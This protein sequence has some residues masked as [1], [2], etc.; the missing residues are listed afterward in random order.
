M[1]SNETLETIYTRR[2]VRKYKDQEVN[3]E[4]IEQVI[5]A[6]RMAPSAINMQPW[7]FYVLT[8]K[9]KIQ[10]YSKAIKSVAAKQVFKMGFKNLVKT[11]VSAIKMSHGISFHKEKDAVFHGAPVVIF[12][13]GDVHNEWAALD[14]GMCVQNMLLASKSIGLDTCP[15]GFAKFIEET[16][17]YT[18]LNIPKSEKVFL[19]VILGYGSE[20]P[21]LHTRKKDNAIYLEY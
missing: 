16:E 18:E 3:K 10:E 6:G 13:A 15:I 7:K 1:Q 19:A 17:I 9:D 5:N 2:S 12:I 4:I 20:S 11:A 8:D 14:L 21:S